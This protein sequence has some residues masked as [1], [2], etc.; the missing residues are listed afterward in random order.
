LRHRFPPAPE[1]PGPPARVLRSGRPELHRGVDLD[2]L[3]EWTGDEAHARLLSG[4]GVRSSIT[5]ALPSREGRLGALTFV[6]G[7]RDY[8]ADDLALAEEIA[9]R[10]GRALENARLYEAALAASRAKSD[11][12]AVMSHELRTPLNAIIGYAQLLLDGVGGELDDARSG[13]LRRIHACAMH[14]LQIIE[15]I[16]AYAQLE[17]GH[18]GAQPSRFTVG[19]LADQVAATAGPLAREK[20]LELRVELPRP[21]AT[22]FTDAARLRQIALNLLSNAVKFTDRGTVGLRAE[23]QGDELLLAVSDTGPGIAPDDLERIYEPFWQA[24]KPLTRH[25]GGTGLGLSVSRRLAELLGGTLTAESHPG[26][27]STF[28][29]RVPAQM[30]AG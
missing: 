9:S 17:A 19:E 27:G 15:E 4:L 26:S 21:G 30:A 16:L 13:Q 18:A 25:A 7:E 11:F 6:C 2:Q 5:V 24:E 20:G 28:T 22:L 12:L 1:A 8:D 23:V 29:V 14:L 3:H 10:A